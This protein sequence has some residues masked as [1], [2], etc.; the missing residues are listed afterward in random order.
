[1]GQYDPFSVKPGEEEIG[2]GPLLKNSN[3]YFANYLLFIILIL[4]AQILE[5]LDT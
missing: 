3:F 1:V 4:L 5:F 2:K